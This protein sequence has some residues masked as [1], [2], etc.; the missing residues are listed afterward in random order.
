MVRIN[1]SSL[2]LFLAFS[3]IVGGFFI[4]SCSSKVNR[5]SSTNKDIKLILI[6]KGYY[7]GIKDN[8][9]SFYV[10]DNQTD[11]D[12]F[13]KRIHSNEI[14]PPKNKN[15]DFSKNIVIAAVYG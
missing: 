3:F 4:F 11:L 8:E 1:K 2:I 12:N 13:H 15:I 7:G 5:N 14:T 9:M 10:F 6:E